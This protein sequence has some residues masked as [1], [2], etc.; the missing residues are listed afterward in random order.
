MRCSRQC[1]LFFRVVSSACLSKLKGSPLLA[2]VSGKPPDS[3]RRIEP[4]LVTRHGAQ[5]K[6]TS[7]LHLLLSPLHTVEISADAPPNATLMLRCDHS[8]GDDSVGTVHATKSLPLTCYSVVAL[9]LR[10]GTNVGA[11]EPITITMRPVQCP[12]ATSTA[13]NF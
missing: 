4:N 9:L 3:D 8:R 5:A 6:L 2:L 10:T 12:P 11:L 7:R 1:W 13:L